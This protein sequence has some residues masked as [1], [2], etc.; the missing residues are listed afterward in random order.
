M[1]RT[2]PPFA[3]WQLDLVFYLAC[4][5]YFGAPLGVC[6]LIRYVARDWFK[7]QKKNSHQVGAR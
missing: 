3:D 1:Q 4:A 7:V 5:V 2:P 6:A